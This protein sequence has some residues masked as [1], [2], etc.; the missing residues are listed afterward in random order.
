VRRAVLLIA[1]ALPTLAAQLL[2]PPPRLDADAVEY[3]SHVRS[4]Y[5]D[6]DLDFA[7][8]FEHFGILGRGDKVRP[9]AT[10]HRR[11]IFSVGPAL[12]WMPFY[13]LGDAVAA[14]RGEREDGYSA[15]HIR[16]V[17][18]ASLAYG[19]AGLWLLHR[20]LGDLVRPAAAFWASFALLYAT[21]LYWYVVQEAAM[22][23]AASFFMAAAVLAAWWPARRALT[24]ARAAAVGALIGLA[25]TVRWQNA[26][27]LLLPAAS[28][29]PR[30]RREPGLA[31]GPGAAALLAF[32]LGALPQMLAWKAIFGLYLLP[33][34]PHGKDF[35]RLDHPYLLNTFFSSRH[36]LLFWTPLLWGAVFGLVAL[37]R[38]DRFTALAVLP[39]IL[40]MSY[41]NACSGD[42]WAGGSFSNRRFDSV[43]PLLGLG[44]AAAFDALL[45]AMRRR[46]GRVVFLAGVLFV[47]WNQLLIVQYAE[48]KIPPDDT[49]SFAAV[50][51]YNAKVLGRHV[52][53]PLAW[54][55]NWVFAAEH[56]LEKA[57]YDLMV[58]KYLF[59][60]QNN[61]G[62]LVKMGDARADPALLG[63]GFGEPRPCE[64]GTCRPVVGLARIMAPLD[65]PE[66][67]EVAVRARGRGTLELRVNGVRVAEFPLAPELARL[68][69][70][71]AE[72]HWRRELNDVSLAVANGEAEV[73]RVTFARAAGPATGGQVR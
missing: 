42:W 4:L 18:L 63:G 15:W 31:L 73:E 2:L 12:L 46:P 64:G 65:V 68:R 3:F 24:P 9:T 20:V 40:V 47:A 11:S 28:L 49:V 21:F 16:A 39:P 62:G 35:L 38:R 48:R 29:L 59:Y 57:R 54:P 7:N 72:V 70:R 41:V 33:D 25:A 51:E 34:P 27:L 36:G 5:F 60:R 13:A 50:T 10:G 44:L 71:V 32:V 61:L 23:H 6:R 58:G 53:T 66:P 26:V 67:L 56:G 55:A 52:G 45:A 22:S 19:V 43:L 14:A 1:L 17:C 30:L 69:A 37:W 8:E